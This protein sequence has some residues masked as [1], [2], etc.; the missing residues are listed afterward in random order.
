[1]LDQ[2]N[3]DHRCFRVIVSQCM[4]RILNLA[5]SSRSSDFD[6]FLINVKFLH[7]AQ[8]LALFLRKLKCKTN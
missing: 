3:L 7:L 2:P 4:F 1:V 5:Y 8:I 6:S